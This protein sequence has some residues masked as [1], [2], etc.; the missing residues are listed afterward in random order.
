[1]P[2]PDKTMESSK[3]D[4]AEGESGGVGAVQ[5]GKRKRRMAEL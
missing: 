4:G 3:G 2:G 1:M 5:R